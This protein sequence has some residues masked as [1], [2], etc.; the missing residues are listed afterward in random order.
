MTNIELK[1]SLVAFPEENWNEKINWEQVSKDQIISVLVEVLEEY[2]KFPVSFGKTDVYHGFSVEVRD[3]RYIGEWGGVESSEDQGVFT[4]NSCPD[5]LIEDPDV[6]MATSCPED[7]DDANCAS[8][9][10]FQTYFS[11]NIQSKG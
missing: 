2:G 8:N 1:K 3:G 9:V 5:D 11:R 4:E 6:F 7:L 10:I